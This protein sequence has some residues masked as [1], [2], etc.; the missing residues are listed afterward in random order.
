MKTSIVLKSLLGTAA[1][2]LPLVASAAST[3]TSGAGTL[4]AT[5][6]VNFTVVIP[7][8]LYL[9]VGTGSAYATGTLTTAGGTDLITFSPAVGAVGNGTAV[10]GVGGDLAG[11]IET[12]AILGN[13]GNVTLVAGV[14]G[15]LS[16]GAGDSI[17]F[18]Q[19]TTAAGANAEATLLAAP[20]LTDTTS[21]ETVPAT[22]KIVKADAKWTFS[23][24]NTVTPAAGTYGGS[25]GN[26]GIVTYTATML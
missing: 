6:T 26:N 20:P 22:N 11:G 15:A 4:T 16:D 7:Q 10:A 21:S 12:A 24:S 3:F 13:G 18:T 23:Y 1:L 9:R 25:A 17:S 8:F 2:T 19:I 5:A 14:T